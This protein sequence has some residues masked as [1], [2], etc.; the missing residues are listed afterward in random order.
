MSSR[1]NVA[2][3]LVELVE[4]K[5]LTLHNL[6]AILGSIEGDKEVQLQLMDPRGHQ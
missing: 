1:R 2:S 5:I 4:C 3:L 6:I